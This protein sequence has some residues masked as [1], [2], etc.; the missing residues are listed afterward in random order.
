[1]RTWA[2]Q[3]G[4]PA[5]ALR[6]QKRNSG[7]AGSP[8]GQRQTVAER[9]TTVTAFSGIGSSGSSTT[10]SAR[11]TET[12]GVCSRGCGAG[13]GRSTRGAVARPARPR[14]CTLPITALRVTSPSARAIWLALSPSVHICFRRSIRSSVQD[15]SAPLD[16]S[17]N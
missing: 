15:M 5:L 9:S 17:V 13:R 8:S 14:R 6:P 11:M 7:V 10:G 4:A 12:R 16:K 3:Y 2:S 1:M